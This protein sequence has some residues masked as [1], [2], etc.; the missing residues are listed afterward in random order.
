MP[1]R[2]ICEPENIEKRVCDAGGVDP[3][4]SPLRAENLRGLPPATVITAAIDPLRS[5]GQAYTKRLREAGSLFRAT[6]YNGVTH[7]FF[8]MGAVVDKAK[9]AVKE[10]ATG[11]RSG[12]MD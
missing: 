4:A 7:E 9:P 3:Y 12:F 10:A 8:S 2:G 5:E 11:L 6:N 1:I